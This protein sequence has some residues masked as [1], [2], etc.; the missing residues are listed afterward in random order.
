MST[1][2]ILQRRNHNPYQPLLLHTHLVSWK[3]TSSRCRPN[4]LNH[5]A[6][7][8]LAQPMHTSWNFVKHCNTCQHYKAQ[9]KKDGH[10]PIPDKQH[11]TNPWHSIAVN[12]IGPLIIP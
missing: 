3:P 9:R 8:H 5:L 6:T 7:F 11:I 12:T 1:I 2:G 10:I 4:V